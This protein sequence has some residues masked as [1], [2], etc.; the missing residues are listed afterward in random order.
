[1][2]KTLKTVVDQE[3]YRNLLNAIRES[4]KDPIFDTDFLDELQKTNCVVLDRYGNVVTDA[5]KITEV[6][7]DAL[8]GY[9]P[10]YLSPGPGMPMA[11]I[12]GKYLGDL[13]PEELGNDVLNVN[14]EE[15]SDLESRVKLEDTMRKRVPPEPSAGTR[16]LSGLLRVVTFGIFGGLDSVKKYDEAVA[17]YND[18]K[19]PKK[20]AMLLKLYQD[21]NDNVKTVDELHAD[22]VK[23]YDPQRGSHV[24][25]AEPS[26]KLNLA[27][28]Q[29]KQILDIDERLKKCFSKEDQDL[30]EVCGDALLMIQKKVS[31]AMSKGD[32]LPQED[33]DALNIM[34]EMNPE[35]L[36]SFSEKLLKEK[37]NLTM[38]KIHTAV[39]QTHEEYKNAQNYEDYMRSNV[40]SGINRSNSGLSAN[41]MGFDDRVLGTK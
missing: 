11:K 38:E 4:G 21:I 9:E 41:G 34:H 33:A 32:A 19:V 7:G 3:K 27:R 28:S 14:A 6:L 20:Q 24:Q 23:K 8:L 13:M 2:S 18:V 1:M 39:S 25:K 22:N 30:L 5:N 10:A 15:I 12:N 36:R 31:D 35:A 17:A 16:F 26:S 40:P 29:N 37:G